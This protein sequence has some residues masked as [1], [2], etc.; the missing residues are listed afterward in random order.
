MPVKESIIGKTA[1][2][3][4]IFLVEEDRYRRLCAGHNRKVFLCD[5]F[6]TAL[7]VSIGIM[8]WDTP[9]ATKRLDAFASASLAG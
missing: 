4:T 6:F 8:Y 1:T 3:T 9:L 2:D 7:R 5:G